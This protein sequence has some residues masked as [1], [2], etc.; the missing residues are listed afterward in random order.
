MILVCHLGLFENLALKLRHP[1]R[2]RRRFLWSYRSCLKRW[3]GLLRWQFFVTLRHIVNL[4]EVWVQVILI[5]LDFKCLYRLHPRWEFLLLDVFILEYGD[6]L[7]YSLLN[8]RRVMVV[9]SVACK[10]FNTCL[11]KYQL[12][13]FRWFCF[14]TMS[15]IVMSNWVL[16]NFYNSLGYAISANHQVRST[17]SLIVT[18]NYKYDYLRKLTCERRPEKSRVLSSDMVIIVESLAYIRG[19]FLKLF[20]IVQ[21]RQD[22]DSTPFERRLMHRISLPGQYYF[23]HYQWLYFSLQF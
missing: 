14:V 17:A 7:V 22:V 19:G 5:L 15:F 18:F 2:T 23:F 13:L 1:N 10:I 11:V 4:F 9:H 6:I 3:L 12:F 21:R 20:L 8:I 16:P